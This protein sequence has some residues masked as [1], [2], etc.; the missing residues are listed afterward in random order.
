MKYNIEVNAKRRIAIG[1]A[2]DLQKTKMRYA[3]ILLRNRRCHVSSF[4]KQRSGI[5]EQELERCGK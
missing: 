5:R 4:T 3:T 1:I 2:I